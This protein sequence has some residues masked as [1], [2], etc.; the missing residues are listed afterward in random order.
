MIE[1]LDELGTSWVLIF[2]GP[3]VQ[4]KIEASSPALRH[5]INS[6]DLQFLIQSYHAD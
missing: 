4:A 3:P 6:G 2:N 5:I 1:F